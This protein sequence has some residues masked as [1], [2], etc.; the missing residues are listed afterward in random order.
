MIGKIKGCIYTLL[1]LLF[2]YIVYKV[3]DTNSTVNATQL[4]VNSIV[5]YINN[6]EEEKD[7]ETQAI[8]FACEPVEY[9]EED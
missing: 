3:L 8:G 1:T 5:Q 4:S 7:S 6:K 2:A 9:D